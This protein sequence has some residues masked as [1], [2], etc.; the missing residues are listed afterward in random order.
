MEHETKHKDHQ[1]RENEVREETLNIG[2][3]HCPNL[4]DYVIQ[5]GTHEGWDRKKVGFAFA[6][7]ELPQ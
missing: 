7:L 6:S 2:A 1:R 4:M 5:G 3:Y